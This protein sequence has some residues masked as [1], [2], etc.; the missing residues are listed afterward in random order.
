M[1][2]GREVSQADPGV[3]LVCVATVLDLRSWRH[4]IP[5]FLMCNPVFSQL[6]KTPGLVRWRVKTDLPHRRFYT[7][8]QWKDRTSMSTFVRTH[9]HTEA[10]RLMGKWSGSGLASVEW[11]SREGTINWREALMRLQKPT[12]TNKRP[13]S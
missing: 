8:T 11:T 12:F 13:G 1:E 4:L 2:R 5:F 7:F 10:V 3:E 9:P 6:N